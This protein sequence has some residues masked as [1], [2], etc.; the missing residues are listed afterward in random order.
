MLDEVR[1]LFS[2]N[3]KDEPRSPRAGTGFERGGEHR[4]RT[5]GERWL[6]RLVG[7]FFHRSV[8]TVPSEQIT[9]VTVYTT[10]VRRVERPLKAYEMI[11]TTQGTRND[12]STVPRRYALRSASDMPERGPA[13]FSWPSL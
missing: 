10:S 9:A 13:R 2:P 6:W 4:K 11:A 5:D 8:M 7:L 3:V 12:P 1:A